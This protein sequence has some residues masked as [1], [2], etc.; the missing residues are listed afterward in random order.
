M[1]SCCRLS[2]VKPLLA[3]TAAANRN[4]RHTIM[5]IYRPQS[6][7]E[8]TRK[9]PEPLHGG[10]VLAVRGQTRDSCCG[11]PGVSFRTGAGCHF[12]W[13]FEPNVTTSI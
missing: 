6:F 10:F 2:D 4:V 7:S 3:E 5:G 9:M 1:L 12:L 8:A 13:T 11:L